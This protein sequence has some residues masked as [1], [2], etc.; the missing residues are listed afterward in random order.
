MRS[1]AA[2]CILVNLIE[3]PSCGNNSIR[4]TSTP[5]LIFHTRKCFTLPFV[6]TWSSNQLTHCVNLSVTWWPKTFNRV[7]SSRY[8]FQRCAPSWYQGQFI[9]VLPC[10]FVFYSSVVQ[11]I[12][13]IWT[14]FSLPLLRRVS[15]LSA[16]DAI[17]TP[18][19]LS[20]QWDTRSLRSNFLELFHLSLFQWNEDSKGGIQPV[21]MQHINL[22]KK[23]DRCELLKIVED[24]CNPSLFS[25]L[26][27]SGSRFL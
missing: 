2:K 19:F 22:F 1:K 24:R 14:L 23:E 17:V 10:T 6:Y 11:F 18:L 20:W 8:A 5:W 21:M 3:S 15:C 12:A 27:I 13:K 16:W 4:S 25:Y 7:Y 26:W 9:F